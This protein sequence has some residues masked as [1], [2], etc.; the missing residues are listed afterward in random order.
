MFLNAFELIMKIGAYLLH[1][2]V[3]PAVHFA[4]L[5][6][7]IV[8]LPI[9]ENIGLLVLALIDVPQIVG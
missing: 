8:H 7:P 1:P 5:Q 6:H 9:L 2:S 3:L 4:G